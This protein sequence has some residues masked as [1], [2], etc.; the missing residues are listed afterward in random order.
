MPVYD[1]PHIDIGARR[2]RRDYQDRQRNLSGSGVPRT[3]EE[4]GA[5][6]RQQLMDV[7]Q[8]SEATRPDRDELGA[9]EGTYIEVELLRGKHA[10]TVL[11][12]KSRGMHPGAVNTAPNDAEKV[13]LYVPDA[14]RPVLQQI[15]DSYTDG[16]L[17]EG[18]RPQQQGFVEPIEEIRDALLT[19]FWTDDPDA[20]PANADDQIWWELWC[21]KGTEDH[22]VGLIRQLGGRT[23]DNDLWMRFPEMVVIPTFATRAAIELLIFAPF[24]LLE[25]RRA[26]ANPT[27]FTDVHRDEQYQW[28]EHLAERTVW[29]GNDVPAVCLFDTGV[30]RAH[31]LIEPALSTD[32]LLAAREAWGGDDSEGHGTQMAGLALHG[33]LAPRLLDDAPHTLS[34]RLESVKLLPPPGFAPNQPNSLGPITQS[35]VARSEINAPER[36]RVFC[37]AITN[38]DVSGAR[39]STWSAAIDQAAAGAMP[40]DEDE[41]PKRLFVLSAGNIPAEIERH[42]LQPNE[43]YPIEDPSQAW[44][45]LTVGGYTDKLDITE[46]E[47]ADYTPYADVGDLS[48]FSRTSE[49]WPSGKS[50]Y[51]PDIVMEA[52]NRALSPD[53]QEVYSTESLSL[54]TTG[55]DVDR[56][57]LT[58][59]AATSAAAA[60]AARLAVRLS[61]QYPDYWPETI[62]ALIVHSAEWTPSMRAQIEEQAGFRDRYAYLRRFGYGVPSY[63]R[64][65]ASAQSHLALV[66]ESTLQPYERANGRKKFKDCHFYALPWPRAS[67]EQL[68]ET[69]VR[70]KVTL[71]YFIEPNPGVSASLNPQRYQSFG[72]RFELR[73]PLET[74]ENFVKRA[75][76]LE[77]EHVKERLPAAGDETGWTFGVRS[78]SAGSLHCDEWVGPAATLANRD[79]LCIKPIAGWWRD[80]ASKSIAE[81]EAR[82]S[83]VVTLQTE[84]ETVELHT[85]IQQVVNAEIG[86]EIPI[87][88]DE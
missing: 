8:R 74:R 28:A 27:F 39:A 38:Q 46:E 88:T 87:R 52:G 6:I 50:P 67:L 54:L 9:R 80:R 41:A 83:L 70:L 62:R 82:Y 55:A 59:F 23:A 2:V 3:R 47:L 15:L 77:R 34:H 63:E 31:A 29:P 43:A 72:L 60:Q 4:H 85:L 14:G 32:D 7:F 18:G 26:S 56:L 58:A 17:T 66:T 81:Q 35:G 10:E 40:G 36:H 48:P 37:M 61:A 75:N 53:E 64:A 25:L 65:V 21:F 49:A 57:P 69:L 44:N 1:Q 68:G 86:I 71:S 19:S 13:V 33:D 12:K 5:R 30:N 22:T 11:E 73:R 16:E 20:L 76:V 84:D 24:S 45:A 79:I 78:I 51:K 42:R